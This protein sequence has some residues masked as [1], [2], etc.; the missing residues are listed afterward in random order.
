[1]GVVALIPGAQPEPHEQTGHGQ[2]QQ[3]L[4]GLGHR[5]NPVL[6][7]GVALTEGQ[8]RNE[9]TSA[10]LTVQVDYVDVRPGDVDDG[11]VVRCADSEIQGGSAVAAGAGAS[12]AVDYK[13]GVAVFAFGAE[14]LMLEGVIGGQTFSFEPIK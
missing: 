11:R 13:D 7:V 12:A 2:Q 5:L 9:L 8:A 10:G 4:H 1:M 3:Q 14:G 6:H